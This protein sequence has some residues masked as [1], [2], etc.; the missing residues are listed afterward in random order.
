VLDLKTGAKLTLGSFGAGDESAPFV[1]RMARSAR[2]MLWKMDGDGKYFVFRSQGQIWALAEK[3]AFLRRP[4]DKPIQ[5]T[6]SPLSLSTPLPSKDGKKHFVIGR[7]YRGELERCESKSGRF[8]PFLSGISAEDVPYSKDGQRVAYVSYPEGILRRSKPDGSEKVQLSYPPLFAALPR[9]SPDGK[10]IALFDYT[11]GK[12]VRIYLGSA[13]GGPAKQL[14]PEDPEP[15]W[16]PNWS[17][18]GDKIMFSGAPPETNSTIRVLD[19]KTHQMS[20][21]AGSRGLFAARWSPTG[22]ASRRCRGTRLAVMIF[23]FQTQKWSELDL[24]PLSSPVPGP[25]PLLWWQTNA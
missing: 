2:R 19:L 4:T 18:E 13:D 23:D 14:L 3:G 16:D 20:M 6:S 1:S 10:Q 22:G 9:W 5:L 25:G 21:L 8:T 7:T 12:P 24:S 17:P 15:Q 11:V